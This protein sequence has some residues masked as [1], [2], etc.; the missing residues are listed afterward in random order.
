MADRAGTRALRTRPLWPMKTILLVDDEPNLRALVHTT[1]RNPDW[2]VVDA[3]DGPAALQLA[4]DEQ[5]DLIVLDWTIPGTTGVDVVRALRQDASTARIPVVMLTGKG[6][7]A[8]RDGTAEA[9]AQ[10]QLAKPFRPR[11]LLHK[12]QQ[13]LDDRSQRRPQ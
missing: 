5:P 4:R 6:Q 8:Q 7:P 1:L 11:D 3:A 10:A 12:V 2:R 13:L 9:G